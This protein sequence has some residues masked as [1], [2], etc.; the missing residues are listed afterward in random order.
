LRGWAIQLE[1][2][3]APAGDFGF[4][5]TV[6][7]TG[8]SG[9]DA[10]RDVA[11]DA[12]GNAYVVGQFSGTADFDP[13]PGTYPLTATGP[14]TWAFAAK[15]APD[16]SLVWAR[17]IAPKPADSLGS[18]A[19]DAAG[20]VYVTGTYAA[21][22]DF[23]PGPGQDVLPA[24]GPVS[25]F[26]LKLD[27]DGNF[28]W[29]DGVTGTG[30]YVEASQIAVGGNGAVVVTGDFSGAADFDPGPATFPLDAGGANCGFVLK[31]DAAGGFA[32]AQAYRASQ[33]VYPTGLAVDANGIYTTGTFQGGVDFDPGPGLYRLI[34]ASLHGDAFVAKLNLDGTFGWAR[35]VG[36]AFSDRVCG[37][38]VAVDAGGNVFTTGLFIGTH[39]FDPGPGT[40]MLTSHPPPPGGD[41]TSDMFV[42]KLDPAGQFLWARRIG[43]AGDDWGLGITVDSAGNLYTTGIFSKSV[44]FDEGPAAATLT[45]TGAHQN[46]LVAKLDADGD[47]RWA[48]QIGR[49]GDAAGSAIA[50]TAAGAVYTTGSFEGRD[51]FDPGPGSAIRTAVS[52]SDMF[53]VELLQK[54]PT[55]V[56]YTTRAGNGSDAL[57]LRRRGELLE[58]L[59]ARAGRVVTARPFDEVSAVIVTGVDGE[60]D[61][62]TVDY[63]GGLFRPPHGITFDGGAGGPDVLRVRGADTDY[64]LT[65]DALSGGNGISIT[66]SGVEAAELNGGAGT[67]VLDASG[68]T[69]RVLLDGGPGNDLLRGSRGG[70]RLR[71]GTGDDLLDANGADADVSGG[72]GTDTLVATADADFALVSLPLGWADLKV[73]APDGTPL[74]TQRLS[75]V[76]RAALSGG[77]GNNVLDASR[78]RGA[79]TLS[80]GSG[81]D[82][83]LGGSGI[84]LLLGGDGNDVLA[85]GAGRNV[86]IGGRGADSLSGGPGDDLL[87]AGTTAY[88]ADPEAVALI[89][90]EWASTASYADRVAH[91]QAGGGLTGG[92]SLVGSAGTAQ[93]VFA[94]A[95]VDSLGGGPGQDWFLASQVAGNGAAIDEVTDAVAGEI[96]TETDI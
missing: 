74:C 95:D 60:S 12:A 29:A 65:D 87:V 19:V 21:D 16:G 34:S 66:L 15:Y 75:G 59:D 47:Y 45:A 35:S 48:R 79:V 18:V 5:V 76:E 39:D 72:P 2:R 67:N 6:G 69:G 40:T 53:L 13:G 20:G 38:D 73:T 3:A 23:D 7:G 41:P 80:G 52:D 54:P 94:D 92:R 32:W 44:D 70:G 58:L 77:D 25:T 83:L 56:D 42:S 96:Y 43:G 27:T 1:D 55:P 71:G 36:T 85:G 4:V 28:V 91:I 81:N 33:F 88:D 82:S 37:S 22:T 11:T 24:L 90:A 78:F 62:L 30:A 84:D 61:A 63:S 89:L 50:V 93:T 46:A 49:G 64:S 9:L 31:L 26:V 68:F 86:L 10:G 51:D 57:V 8:G 14:G 17:A